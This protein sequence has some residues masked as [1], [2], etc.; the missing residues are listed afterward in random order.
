MAAIHP[1]VTHLALTHLAVGTRRADQGLFL[2]RRRGPYGPV[3]EPMDRTST[4][5]T[6]STADTAST[7]G[8]DMSA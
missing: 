6:A 7:V 2:A 5:D 8:L 1:A 4:V 3:M